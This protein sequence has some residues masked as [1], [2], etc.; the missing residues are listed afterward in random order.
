MSVTAFQKF[1]GFLAGGVDINLGN[2]IEPKIRNS[3]K[4]TLMLELHYFLGCS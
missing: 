1:F 2:L 4:W 3:D